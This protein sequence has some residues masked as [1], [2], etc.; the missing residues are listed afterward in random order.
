MNLPAAEGW[1]GE[2]GVRDHAGGIET[3]FATLEPKQ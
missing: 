3:R 2:A 1:L